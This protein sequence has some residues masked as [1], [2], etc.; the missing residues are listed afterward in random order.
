MNQES[1]PHRAA[2]YAAGLLACA[3]IAAV[4][5][6]LSA[7]APLAHLGI[8]ALTLAI[9]L[10]I[11]AGNLVP[12]SLH[13]YTAPGA[14]FAQRRLLR[15]GVAL[16][17]LRLT[18]QQVEA[19]GAVAIITDVLVITS[20]LALAYWIGTRVLKLDR[21]TSLLVATGSAI[22]GAAAV[23]AAEPVVRAPPHKVAIAV[24][25]V[26]VFGSLAIFVY[27]LLY[28][29]LGMDPAHFGVYIGSTVHEVA[30]VVAAG[31]AV[32][33]ATADEA[34][35][36]KLI[37]VLMLAPFLLI[38]GRIMRRGEAGAGHSREAV[39][40]PGFVLLFAVAV[41]VNSLGWVPPVLR[42]A[43]LQADGAL[44]AIAMA[45]L[46]WAT[47]ARMLKQAGLRPL[48]LGAVMFVFL[49]GGG[50]AINRVVAAVLS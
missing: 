43:L 25:T 36:V 9:A 7:W 30:Q 35:I 3:G 21:E 24:A 22:C 1:M 33:P 6:Q 50:Y 45:A 17:G 49:I 18:V 29:L 34:V 38:L 40:V 20:V 16:Y 26:T 2:R 44:L 48:V 15:L 46:G 31:R 27:P 5:T 39:G 14:G 23:M 42:G 12:G 4:A 19:V 13:G 37:R 10:G 8:G 41:G 11:V 28:P 32:A 47:H